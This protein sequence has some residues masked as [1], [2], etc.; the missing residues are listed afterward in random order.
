MEERVSDFHHSN[1]F[2]MNNKETQ[3]YCQG[4]GFYVFFHQEI[5]R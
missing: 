5:R 2:E 3:F 1:A 4:D